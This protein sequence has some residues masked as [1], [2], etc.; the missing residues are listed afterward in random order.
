MEKHEGDFQ[1]RKIVKNLGL[2]GTED[3]AVVLEC[4]HTVLVDSHGSSEL[5]DDTA[6][7]YFCA[8]VEET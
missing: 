5:H 6:Y 8:R 7:C 1:E 2:G 4:G 3:F